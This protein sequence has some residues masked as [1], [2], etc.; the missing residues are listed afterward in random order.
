VVELI[1]DR[2]L[3]LNEQ[4][5]SILEW[6][7]GKFAV[8]EN[9]PNIKIKNFDT[10]TF[11]AVSDYHNTSIYKNGGIVF[12]PHRTHLFGVTD[13]FKFDKYDED[14]LCTETGKILHKRGEFV[15]LHPTNYF[16]F[17]L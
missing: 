11:Y 15:C 2:L 9:L 16:L 12:C 4:T 8:E 17:R 13:K 5:N 1:P 7:K 14:V 6:T 10:H 3:K